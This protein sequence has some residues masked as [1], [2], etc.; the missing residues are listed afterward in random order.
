MI[1]I[2]LNEKSNNNICIQRATANDVGEIYTLFSALFF[3]SS[4]YSISSSHITWDEMKL[5]NVVYLKFETFKL[6][7]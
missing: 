6:Y 2:E 1:M 7:I 3:S 4:T 5:K